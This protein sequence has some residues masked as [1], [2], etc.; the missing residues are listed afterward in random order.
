MLGG[1]I[2]L[3]VFNESFSVVDPSWALAGI[4]ALHRL[5]ESGKLKILLSVHLVKIQSQ[6]IVELHAVL[7]FD[8]C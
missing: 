2:S 4:M 5:L 8:P 7:E 1:K 6:E 3:K